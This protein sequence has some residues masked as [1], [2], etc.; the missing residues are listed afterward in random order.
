VGEARMEN[1]NVGHRPPVS[2]RRPRRQSKAEAEKTA[3]ALA[4]WLFL[5]EPDLLDHPSLAVHG[6][7]N[8]SRRHNEQNIGRRRGGA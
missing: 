3:R 4:V 8:L 5:H 7:P 6:A 2:E 1:R